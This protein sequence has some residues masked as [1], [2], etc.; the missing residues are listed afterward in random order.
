MTYHL[1]GRNVSEKNV[2]TECYWAVLLQKGQV[3]DIPKDWSKATGQW[4]LCDSE[5]LGFTITKLP[6]VFYYWW[7]CEVWTTM[8]VTKVGIYFYFF[9]FSYTLYF[10][11]KSYDCKKGLLLANFVGGSL[12]CIFLT[13]GF[14]KV[15]RF[16]FWERA[17]I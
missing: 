11:T 9:I 7:L 1:W 5:M 15:L 13:K 14:P 6:S 8:Q 4:S 17:W 12:R 3:N 16:Y 10:P 2:G